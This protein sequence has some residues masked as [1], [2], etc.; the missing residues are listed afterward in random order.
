MVEDRV[1]PE[2]NESWDEVAKPLEQRRRHIVPLVHAAVAWLSAL[3]HPVAH[4]NTI[5][6]PQSERGVYLCERN[7]LAG[8]CLLVRGKVPLLSQHIDWSPT[9]VV[10]VGAGALWREPL[11][12]PPQP[13]DKTFQANQ[14]T[15]VNILP[16]TPKAAAKR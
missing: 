14:T 12:S 10:S 11:A 7:G 1:E 4:Y 16:W 5:P 6:V 2:S 13:D 8:R 9:S 15:Q 3:V